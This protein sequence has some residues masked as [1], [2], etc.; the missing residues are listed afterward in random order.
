[1][2][3]L[4]SRQLP[5]SGASLRTNTTLPVGLLE[6]NKQRNTT[7]WLVVQGRIANV[8]CVKM[9]DRQAECIP[10]FVIVPKIGVIKQAYMSWRIGKTYSRLVMISKTQRINRHLAVVNKSWWANWYVGLIA[11]NWIVKSGMIYPLNLRSIGVFV[12]VSWEYSR[13]VSS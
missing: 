13:L 3:M 10:V 4:W 5:P 6:L 7:F 12:T 8:S 2:E 1:M 11:G 9:V